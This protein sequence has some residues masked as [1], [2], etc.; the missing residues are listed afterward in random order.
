MIFGGRGGGGGT[1]QL[2]SWK[3]FCQSCVLNFDPPGVSVVEL[4]GA[5]PSKPEAGFCVLSAGTPVVADVKV[6]DLVAR[7]GDAL[8]GAVEFA[9]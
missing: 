1:T 9:K 2:P 3:A 5:A 6:V 8:R 4:P 7:L